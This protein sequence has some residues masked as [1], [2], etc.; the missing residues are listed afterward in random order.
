VNDA[1][2]HPQTVLLLGAGSDI[3][4]AIARALVDRGTTTVVLA[5]RH[6]DAYGALAADLRARGATHVDAL[7]FDA[8]DT[9]SHAGV[10]DDVVSRVGDIDLAVLAWGVL[11]D[12]QEAEHDPKATVDILETNFV[13]AASMGVVL[14]DRLQTQG[15]GRILVLSSVAGER[16]RASNFIY[17]SSKAGVDAFFTGLGDR[18]VGTGVHVLVVRPGFVHT[19]MTAG[20]KAAPLSTDAD[21]VAAIAIAALERGASQVWAPRPLRYVMSAL[22]H[23]PRSLFRRLPL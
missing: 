21:A 19:K 7:R 18:L 8:V 20:L 1:L 23:V 22:R 10:I 6:P 9:G 2:G 14:A 11:G 3:G 17:G 13:G 16:A 4:A 5:G 15:H 12:Q